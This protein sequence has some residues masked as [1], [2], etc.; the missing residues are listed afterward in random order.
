MLK[1][2]TGLNH[3]AIFSE[4]L[5]KDVSY[6]INRFNITVSIRDMKFPKLKS[7]YIDMKNR[8]FPVLLERE[9]VS[10]IFAGL[11][12]GNITQFW[13][14]SYAK[15]EFIATSTNSLELLTLCSPQSAP[16]LSQ[17]LRARQASLSFSC[18]EEIFY[19]LCNPCPGLRKL[20][21]HHLRPCHPTSRE[22]DHTCHAALAKVMKVK[23]EVLEGLE[24]L[25]YSTNGFEGK[26]D[27]NLRSI[28][29]SMGKML[30]TL[31]FQNLTKVALPLCVLLSSPDQKNDTRLSSGTQPNKRISHDSARVSGRFSNSSFLAFV[32]NVPGLEHL[33]IASCPDLD[34]AK[35]GAEDILEAV[36]KLSNL[37]TLILSKI[38]VNFSS[39]PLFQRIFCSCPKLSHLHLNSLVCDVQKL[40]KDLVLGLKQAHSLRILKLFQKQWTQHSKSLLAALKESCLQLEQ[41]VII[42]SSKAFTLKQFPLAELVEIA[43]KESICLLYITSELLTTENIKKLKSIMRKISLNKP[44]FVSRFVKEFVQGKYAFYQLADVANLPMVYHRAVVSINSLSTSYCSNSSVANVTIEDVF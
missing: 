20:S 36:T 28:M 24:E 32:D 13:C 5:H 21:L 11:E 37:E 43:Q 15:R 1:H 44:Y 10:K 7:L 39:K 31:K 23:Q 34:C 9:F 17:P 6:S 41:L 8:T 12:A 27:S 14:S 19:H 22:L 18:E 26:G 16:S 42:D 38:L 29:F 33:E 35:V 3:L 4:F 40:C 25:S 2:C 30:A